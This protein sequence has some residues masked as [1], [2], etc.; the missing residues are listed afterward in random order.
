MA[1]N[2]TGRPSPPEADP[3]QDLRRPPVTALACGAAAILLAGLVFV[4]ALR[5][6]KHDVAPPPPPLVGGD[7]AVQ[8]P[9]PPS[10]K[11]ADARTIAAE[12]ATIMRKTAAPA[13][14]PP[15]PSAPAP[16][17]SMGRSSA[18]QGATARTEDPAVGKARMLAA[19]RQVPHGSVT[20]SVEDDP[21]AQA[22][23]RQLADLFHEAGWTVDEAS[24]FG[25]GPPRR[26]VAVAFGGAPADEAVRE[27]FDAVGFH[28]SPPP[29]ADIVQTPEIF[30]GVPYA[31]PPKP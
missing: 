16:Q 8:A 10:P 19:L 1:L 11:L 9:V 27:A 30:V 5:Q 6:H 21:Q 2:F 15:A 25:S 20:L 14:S 26:G 22:L 24:A 29:S 31:A 17:G 13:A 7:A 4:V 23:A 28:F 18:G 12:P 3:I